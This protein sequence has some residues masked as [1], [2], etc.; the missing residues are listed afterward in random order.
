[1]SSITVE[2]NGRIRR[3]QTDWK[4][5]TYNSDQFRKLLAKVPDFELVCTHDFEFNIDEC[6]DLNDGQYD[7]LVVLRR[8][9]N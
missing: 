4:F 1:R 5:R 7:V 9:E 2:E 3:T 8:R 6:F